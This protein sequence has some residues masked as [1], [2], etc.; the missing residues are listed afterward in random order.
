M[1]KKRISLWKINRRLA[2]PRWPPQR[3]T[4]FRRQKHSDNKRLEMTH[5]AQEQIQKTALQQYEHRNKERNREKHRD[6]TRSANNAR[7]GISPE[8]IERAKHANKIKKRPRSDKLS[9]SDR[10]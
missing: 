7:T 3:N 6:E 8:K 5:Q 10:S 2:V 9:T 1:M 4:I